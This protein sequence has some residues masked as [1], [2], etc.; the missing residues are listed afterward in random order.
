M[1][2][3]VFG[4]ALQLKAY[5]P[6]L[7][8]ETAREIKDL[9]IKNGFTFKSDIK[10]PITIKKITVLQSPH[11]YKKSREQFE[12]RWHTRVIIIESKPDHLNIISIAVL[13]KNIMKNT[14][15]YL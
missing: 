12:I 14:W 7:L 11:V 13:I 2:T 4:F 5:N 9:V 6:K 8:E 3:L 1:T 10:L 15:Q